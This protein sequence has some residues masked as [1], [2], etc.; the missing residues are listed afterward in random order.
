MGGHA[1]GTAVWFC[2][3]SRVTDHLT[4][5][6]M[7]GFPLGGISSANTGQLWSSLTSVFGG[8]GPVT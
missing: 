3:S 2:L 4:L 1:Q 5:P 7:G 8:P 6:V